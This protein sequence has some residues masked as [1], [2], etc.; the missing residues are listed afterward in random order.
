M[1]LLGFVATAFEAAQTVLVGDEVRSARAQHWWFADLT[2]YGNLVVLFLQVFCTGRWMPRTSPVLLLVALPLLSV[3]GLSVYWWAPTAFAIFCVQVARRGA[4]YAIEKP[5]REV[6][7]TPLD[8]A[9][10]H[11]VKFFVDTFAF[12]L[13]DWVGAAAQA[14]MHGAS[15][16]VGAI[17]SITVAFAFAW[18]ALAW[19]LG[20]D[21]GQR[22]SASIS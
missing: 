1:M 2:L 5:A 19:S 3:V 13:G 21:R 17:V 15:L 7:Y 10:K 22:V 8:L 6:L 9:T 18:G 12:R 14:A 16:S 4:N 20:R 11:K